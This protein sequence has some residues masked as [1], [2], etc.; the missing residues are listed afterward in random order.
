ME[1]QDAAASTSATPFTESP[2]ITAP[3]SKAQKQLEYRRRI[4]ASRTPAQAIA[5]RKLDAERQRNYRL[6]KAANLAL[7]SGS[8]ESTTAS[9]SRFTL[10]VKLQQQ[11]QHKSKLLSYQQS[12][13]EN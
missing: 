10:N 12:L 6:R 3:K 4:A 9:S 2:A 1:V 7:V 11:N 13:L 8:L 5:A